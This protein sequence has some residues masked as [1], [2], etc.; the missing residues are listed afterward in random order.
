[1]EA[2]PE[3]VS[4]EH[5]YEQEKVQHHVDEPSRE[6]DGPLENLVEILDEGLKA[7]EKVEAGTNN[8]VHLPLPGVLVQQVYVLLPASPTSPSRVGTMAT[9]GR[10]NCFQFHRV[11][12]RL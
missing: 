3:Q 4:D 5:E 2:G 1:M 6:V 9:A 11:F 7:V 12:C 8:F 10:G